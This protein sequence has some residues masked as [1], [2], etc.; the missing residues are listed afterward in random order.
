MR[1]MK[2]VYLVVGW[3]N[4]KIARKGGRVIELGCG[5]P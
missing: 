3:K 2:Y 5:R 4:K 1:E